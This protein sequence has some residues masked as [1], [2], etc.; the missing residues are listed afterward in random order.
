M[1]SIS[2]TIAQAIAWGR[3]KV[4]RQ[5]WPAI[6]GLFAT[7]LWGATSFAQTRG[8]ERDDRARIVGNPVLPRNPVKRPAY[9]S[10]GSR[11]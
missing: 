7:L 5:L 8:L 3:G 1:K 2:Y 4:H 9:A 11:R 10:L 6:A